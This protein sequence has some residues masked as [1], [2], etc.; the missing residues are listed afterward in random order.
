[1]GIIVINGKVGKKAFIAVSAL[2]GA[3][4]DID[5]VGGKVILEYGWPI[6]KLFL[7][8]VEQGEEKCASCTYSRHRVMQAHVAKHQRVNPMG[9]IGQSYQYSFYI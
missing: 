1:M 3:C 4:R 8:A 5:G 9:L 7:R 6:D 2:Q